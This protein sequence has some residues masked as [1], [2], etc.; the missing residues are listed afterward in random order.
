MTTRRV[1]I[2]GLSTYWGGRLAQA[3]EA[4]PEIEAII[5]VDNRDPKVELERTEFVRVT[6]QHSLL[7]R[8]VEA[9]MRAQA[10]IV[11][12]CVVGA[13]E[14]APVFAQMTLL[15]KLTGLLYFPITPTFPHFGLLGMLGYLPAQFKL[16]FLE[17]IE[18]HEEGLHR[19]KSMVQS[20]A[21][22]V[23]RR[24]QENVWE[25]VGERE[26]VWFG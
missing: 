5:G 11:P 2:T 24:I 6:N 25:M 20:V 21:Q 9:A 22:D 14:A 17:P 18:F 19:D 23:R 16:R 7:R 1:L 15:Q 13:E 10:P 4:Q 26:S 8:I 12:V 3:L